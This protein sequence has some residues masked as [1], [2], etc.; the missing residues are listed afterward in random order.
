MAEQPVIE[1][2][3]PDTPRYRTPSVL[4]M[5]AVECGAASLAMVLAY[6][7]RF[8]SLEELR[9][10]CGVTRD[11]TKASNVLKAAR[12][13]GMTA[14]GYKKEPHE[15]R[16]M[17]LPQ[18]VFWNFNHFVVV[19]GFIKGKVYL[20]D[21]AAGPRVVSDDEFDQSFTGV[22]LTFEAGPDFKPGGRKPNVIDA[23]KKRF[24]GMTPAVVYLVLVGLALVVPGLVIPVFS[25]IFVDKFLVGGLTGWLKP[26]LVGMAVTALLKMALTWLQSYY[27][28]RVQTQLA[29]SSASKFFWH[30]LRLPVEFY[31][32][33]SAGEIS[34]RVGIND[35]VAALLSGDL[36]QAVLNVI[37]AIFFAMLMFFYDVTLTLISV[38]IVSI[39]LVVMRLISRRM[40][41][42]SQKLAIDGG[43]VIGASMNGLMV[44]ET[45]KASGSES[46]FFAKWAGFQAKYVNSEQ[47]VTRI[48]LVL[49]S[50]PGL[51]SAANNVLVLGIG[52]LHVI[53][54]QLS[55][56]QLVAFQALVG[57]FIGPVTALVGLGN[58]LQE[59]QGDMNRLDDV[60]Q[61]PTDPWLS[62]ARLGSDAGTSVPP[63][64]EGY[65]ELKQVTF[66]YNRADFPLIEKL[67]LRVEPG[68]RVALV[69]PSG[70]GKSTVSRLVMG[71]YSPWEGEIL[72]DGKPRLSYGRYEFSN[73]VALIDQDIMLFEG[74]FRDNLTMWDKSIPEADIIQAAKDACIHDVILARPGGYDSRIEEG[75]RNMSGGQRQRIEI[76]RALATNPRV[77]VLDEAT[78]ALDVV[79]EKL[80]DDNLRRRG[81]A[82]IIIAH[83]L[84]TIRDADELLVLAHGH[85]MERGTHD[86]LMN[87][88]TGFYKR[89][90]TSQ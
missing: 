17:K 21:P 41:E 87:S 12:T 40:K 62:Q 86:E 50:L 65:V 45:V 73:S 66:G 22:V 27:L 81:C 38:A 82:C 32:Q 64:L 36:A 58:K 79:T 83:R 44:M 53:N 43:K 72:F 16:G 57:S 85:L 28:L 2:K 89:L 31:T 18:I 29:L 42:A 24:V 8:A 61:Y 74:T 14:K 67:D 6:Y 25:S 46:D 54:G 9:L 10:L 35:R 39:N 84:S 78:S 47:A 23:L 19:E 34:T 30:A 76:A 77:L 48:G 7:K 49:G 90:V 80:I 56:G 5:E 20:N 71:L 70:C 26:L 15:L 59:V 3:A 52:G 33:R 55:I 60:M 75:G 51:L 4:Q 63:K 69:G 11:G 13:F 1:P 37:T 88:E 68:Q